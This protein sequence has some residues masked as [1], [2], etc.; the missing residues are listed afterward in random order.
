[1]RY[2]QANLGAAQSDT[3]VE[4]YAKTPGTSWQNTEPTR[5]PSPALAMTAVVIGLSMSSPCDSSVLR[6]AELFPLSSSVNPNNSA[7]T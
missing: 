4:L 2:P 3:W 6:Q 5:R 1:M 7:M